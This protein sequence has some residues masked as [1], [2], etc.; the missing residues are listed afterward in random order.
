MVITG[1]LI[2]A[3][4]ATKTVSA[5]YR[6]EWQV[7]RAAIDQSAN[8]TV[9]YDMRGNHD[10]FDLTSWQAENNYYREFG[11]SSQLLNEGK[12]VYSWQISKPFGD[13]NFVAVD[14]W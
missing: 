13:Y 5:Q 8:G 11:E 12:G 10:C 4:D 2:D 14:A 1:D 3:K 9:W 6:E 7:Y